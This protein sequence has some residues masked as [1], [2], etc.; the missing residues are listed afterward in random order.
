VQR[1]PGVD[2]GLFRPLLRPQ[3][4]LRRE[5]GL[6][7]ARRCC[8]RGAEGIASS[9]EDVPAVSLDAFPQERIVTRERCPH[10]VV[11]GCPQPGAAFDIGEQKGHRTARQRRI[12]TRFC[13]HAG[14]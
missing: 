5:C 7:R 6:D 14:F 1:H 3:R 8:E 4:A 13:G 12:G 10:R 9:L 2:G 11:M